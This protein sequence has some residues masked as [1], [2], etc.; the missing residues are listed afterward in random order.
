MLRDLLDALRCPMP[1]EESW[2]VAMVYEAEG[3]LLRRADLSCPVCAA[4]YII[5][6]GIA[7]FAEPLAGRDDRAPDPM[8]LAALLGVTDGHLPVLLSGRYTLAGDALGAL[9]PVPQVWV[10]AQAVA[11]PGAP[12]LS[13]MLVRDRVP[14]GVATLAAAA[15]DA[16]HAT[17]AML[18]SVIRAVQQ[19]GHVIA[20]AETP[21]PDGLKE[22]ARDG[23]EWVAEVTARASGLIEL[24][25]RA[26]DAVG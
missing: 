7:R 15:V 26:P 16:T 21:L 3:P 24:R 25:R 9:I 22:L 10:N 12:G 4:E 23:E 14:L 17:P 18:A 11:R 8:R 13:E 6:D 20:P 1:H 5:R 19:G 2:L